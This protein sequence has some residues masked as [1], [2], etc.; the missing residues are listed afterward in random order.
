M[1][2]DKT[3]FPEKDLK[4]F[5]VHSPS[6]VIIAG[7]SNSGKSYIC[8][9]LIEKYHQEFSHIIICGVG[10]HE[11]QQRF[12]EDYITVSRE[13]IDPLQFQTTDKEAIL[14]V[15]DDTFM[16]AINSKIVVES[17]TKGRHSNLSVILV[18]QNIFGQGKYSRTIA[19]NASHFILTRNRDICQV[20]TLFRQLFG[21]KRVQD[22]T[23]VYRK[24]V[25]SRPFGYLLIDIGPRT[26]DI[27]QLRSNILDEV[28]SCELVYQLTA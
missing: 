3:C 18:T 23:D 21:K 16:E 6:R 17:F 12:P 26:P 5:S 1:D 14:F 2:D 27:L 7:Y 20:E 25:Y 15:L 19:L 8:T 9:K 10:N 13:I 11:L 28:T 4:V 22:A 24:A